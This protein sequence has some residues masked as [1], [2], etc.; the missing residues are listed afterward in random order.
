MLGGDEGSCA[1]GMWGQV[2]WGCGIRCGVEGRVSGEG[3]GG[4]CGMGM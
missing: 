3:H 4:P 2:R 1:V